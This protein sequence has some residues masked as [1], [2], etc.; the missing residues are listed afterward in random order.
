MVPS[1]VNPIIL[2]KKNATVITVVDSRK[3]SSNWKLYINYTNPMIDER[4]KVLINSLL[5]KK[6]NNEE[7]LLKTD[8]VL[9]YESDNNGEN[10]SVSNVTFSPE[11]GLFL[12]PSKNLLENEDYSTTIIW[13]IEG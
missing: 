12:K 5:F 3:N 7:V 10:I 4:G 1:S 8:K 13:S 9:I 6:F 11:K 2:S